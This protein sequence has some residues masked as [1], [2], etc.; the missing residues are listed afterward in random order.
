M[1]SSDC[2]AED[3]SGVS[4]TQKDQLLRATTQSLAC[5]F[6]PSD[7]SSR[8]RTTEDATE[9]RSNDSRPVNRDAPRAP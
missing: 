3:R 9:R 6:E 5:R 4:W 2:G 7:P 1:K 8:R